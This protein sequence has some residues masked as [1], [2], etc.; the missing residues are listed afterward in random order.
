MNRFARLVK[1]AKNPF[2]LA[3]SVTN[4]FIVGAVYPTA[5]QFLFF[6]KLSRQED[7]WIERC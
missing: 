7:M 4:D 2:R 6:G 3:L 1:C 5:W